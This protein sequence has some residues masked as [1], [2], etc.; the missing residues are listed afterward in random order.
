MP[1][2]NYNVNTRLKKYKVKDGANAD[3]DED[4]TD[5]NAPRK[6]WNYMLRH[7]QRIAINMKNKARSNRML[8]AINR[9]HL[10]PETPDPVIIR[11]S[12]LE[13]LQAPNQEFFDEMIAKA[14]EYGA[15]LHSLKEDVCF[16]GEYPQGIAAH[17][18]IFNSEMAKLRETWKTKE[19]R[20]TTLSP[21]QIHSASKRRGVIEI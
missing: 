16:S 12:S 18:E 21:T 11:I 13:A 15:M 2:F 19:T 14:I 1:V 9:N 5:K 4:L 6:A 20:P 3:F 17:P 7:V 8:N 10:L